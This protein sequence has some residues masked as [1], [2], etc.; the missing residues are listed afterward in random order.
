[1]ASDDRARERRNPIGPT[2]RT[3]GANVK[4]IRLEQQITQAE[5]S[6][7]LRENW[8]PIPTSSIGRIETGDRRVE[9]DDL[10]ALSIALNVS[11][12]ALLLPTTR[13]PEDLVEFTGWG[14]NPSKS[15]WDFSLGIEEL[16]ES[17]PDDPGLMARSFPFWVE[18]RI[19][20]WALPPD[21]PDDVFHPLG[22]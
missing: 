3:V 12:L 19:R 15:V 7:R 2:T 5:L 16:D 14:L 9:V 17:S 1:M 10:V 11:P 18:D 22:D 13:G 21:E 4:R 6:D 20:R 8:H